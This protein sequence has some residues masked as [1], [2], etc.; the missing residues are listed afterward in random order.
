MCAASLPVTLSSQDVDQFSRTGLAPVN[1]AAAS[2]LPPF[3]A[4]SVATTAAPVLG[5]SMVVG[6][7]AVVRALS[8]AVTPVVYDDSVAANDTT[9]VGD[10]VAGDADVVDVDTYELRPSVIITPNLP[11]HMP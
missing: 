6:P 3:A 7:N 1:A 8:T 5:V 9:A 10:S 11:R 2:T 4:T